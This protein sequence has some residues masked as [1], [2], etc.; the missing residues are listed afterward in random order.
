MCYWLCPRLIKTNSLSSKTRSKQKIW[1]LKKKMETM[2]ITFYKLIKSSS[3]LN[4]EVVSS[5]IL[6][7]SGK[8]LATVSLSK[9]VFSS[10]NEYEDYPRLKCTLITDGGNVRTVVFTNKLYF[11]T[12][13]TKVRKRRSRSQNVLEQTR[14]N[15]QANIFI[16]KDIRLQ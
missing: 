11:R 12:W 8:K 3:F 10:G 9:Q 7:C 13:A 4:L 5:R 16:K 15:F 14:K 2:N 1:D 6:H